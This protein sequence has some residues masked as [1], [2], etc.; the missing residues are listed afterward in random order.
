MRV[1]GFMSGTSLDAVDMAAV[2]GTI[3]ELREEGRDLILVTHQMAF[4]R[5]VGDHVAFVADGR[6]IESG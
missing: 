3:E 4:A 6:A 5:R 2:L 1:L